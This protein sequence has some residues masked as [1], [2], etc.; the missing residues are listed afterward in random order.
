MDKF[1]NLIQAAQ[2]IAPTAGPPAELVR[3]TADDT[4]I[5]LFTHQVV[6]VILHYAREPEISS[7]VHCNGGGESR[8]ALCLAGR[9]LEER[10]LLPVYLPLSRSVGV[11]P[12]SH[13]LRPNSL[14]CLLLPHLEARAEPVSPPPLLFV[15][16]QDTR[17]TVSSGLLQPGEDDGAAVVKAFRAQLADG[18]V[19]LVD[20]FPRI[21]NDRLSAIP[22]IARLLALKGIPTALE[23]RA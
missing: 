4:P 9:S 1:V 19:R 15:R 23:T 10:Y 6:E 11:L 3:L 18:R 17:F 13:S 8:C 16:R 7:Y 22:D 21:P 2:A 12:I 20:M 5:V 14:L